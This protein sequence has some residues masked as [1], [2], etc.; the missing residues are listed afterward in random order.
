MRGFPKLKEHG[1]YIEVTTDEMDDFYS[2]KV[3]TSPR[4]R[5]NCLIKSSCNIMSKPRGNF[6][7]V[8]DKYGQQF[9]C[10]S[11]NDVR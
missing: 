9:V 3:L 11:V 1:A 6:F 5:L 7:T 10:M 8:F 2:L 4:E